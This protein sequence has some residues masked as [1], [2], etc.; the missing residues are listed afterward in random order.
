MGSAELAATQTE[1]W[2]LSRSMATEL[3]NSLQ[4]I[5]EGDIVPVLGALASIC[6]QLVSDLNCS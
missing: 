6:D 2:D 1:Q 3:Q 4:T 5:K